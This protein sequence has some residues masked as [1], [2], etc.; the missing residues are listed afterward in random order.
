M[1]HTTDTVKY[2]K[3]VFGD[4]KEHLIDTQLTLPDYYPDI[5]RILFCQVKTFTENCR[6]EGD[7]IILDGLASVRLF[8]CCDEK[9]MHL[10]ETELRFSKTTQMPQAYTADILECRQKIANVSFRAI[11]PRRVDVKTAV[12]V[13]TT[14]SELS[15]IKMCE[16]QEDGIE[17]LL[18][19]QELFDLSA[20]YNG[21]FVIEEEFNCND[22]RVKES[23]ILQDN[24]RVFCTE[25]KVVADKLLIKGYADLNLLYLY[26]KDNTVFKFSE[27]V[28][29]T[30]VIDIYGLRESDACSVTFDSQK[31]SVTARE[32]GAYAVCLNVRVCVCAGETKT[33]ALT[34]D[35]Y[36]S[37][38]H[39]Q[40]HFCDEAICT[41]VRPVSDS[42][43]CTPHTEKTEMASALV[44]AAHGTGLS[45]ETAFSQGKMTVQGSLM[46]GVLLAVDGEHQY[47]TR[48]LGFEYSREYAQTQNAGIQCAVH[49]KNV[50]C[51][52]AADALNIKAELEISGCILGEQRVRFADSY[53]KIEDTDVQANEEIISVYFAQPGESV[54]DIAK[55][56]KVP[57]R[58]LKE[59]N[60]L[61]DD[62]IENR[63]VL[64]LVGRT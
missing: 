44:L 19:Q 36:A 49:C 17:R 12:S 30:Q 39:I 47:I 8:Y 21:S 35:L 18:V 14:L 64:V 6:P 56:N 62:V 52:M 24:T 9:K 20:Y 10:Y 57:L 1:E 55:A 51:S 23:R 42:F 46:V 22:E 34:R 5:C 4:V 13:S 37:R 29:F 27:N 50:V 58:S 43:L 38:G 60:A 7:R 2:K 45:Y 16:A 3:C 33:I 48:S 59:T 54:W 26:D 40:A 41:D 32:T 28:P 31:M 15:E 11:G 61:T 25:T 53:E 63:S